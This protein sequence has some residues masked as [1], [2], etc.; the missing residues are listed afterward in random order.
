MSTLDTCTN[1]K[2]EVTGYTPRKNSYYWMQHR[3]DSIQ[4]RLKRDI[5]PYVECGFD[6]QQIKEELAKH[7]QRLIT[8]GQIESVISI[9][10]GEQA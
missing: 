2:G 5:A 7:G 9:I 3:A 6:A 8:I 10:L 1:Y 4:S